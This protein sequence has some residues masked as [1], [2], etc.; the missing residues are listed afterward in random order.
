MIQP[1]QW[2]PWITGSTSLA[3]KQ[4]N[5]MHSSFGTESQTPWVIFRSLLH[6]QVWKMV[7]ALVRHLHICFKQLSQERAHRLFKAK[8]GSMTSTET[9]GSGLKQIILLSSLKYITISYTAEIQS[10]R[11]VSMCPHNLLS[12]FPGAHRA[13]TLNLDCNY[14]RSTWQTGPTSIL[15]LSGSVWG[16]LD[17]AV[18]EPQVVPPVYPA[19]EQ[20][21]TACPGSGGKRSWP[22]FASDRCSTQL[23]GKWLGNLQG[24]PYI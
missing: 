4:S 10:L 6:G 14:Q 1:S 19:A 2:G 9:I 22:G 8:R 21:S 24:S 7:R 11:L 3:W 13:V 5:Q 17:A 18:S 23:L 20:Q 12:P 15:S 16:L